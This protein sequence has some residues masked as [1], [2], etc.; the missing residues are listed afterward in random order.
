M[1]KFLI[2]VAAVALLSACATADTKPV[3]LVAGV[4]P[5]LPQ[6]SSGSAPLAPTP[7]PTPLFPILVHAPNNGPTIAQINSDGTITGD[8]KALTELLDG[9]TGQPTPESVI[10]ALINRVMVDQPA[11]TA[12]A[13]PSAK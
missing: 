5:A 12:V 13:P 3:N 2:S 6:P 7:P 11:N 8:K 9:M 4:S 1:T 10:F